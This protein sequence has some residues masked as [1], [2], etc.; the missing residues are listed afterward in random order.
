MGLPKRILAIGA[1][2]DDIEL[3]CAGTLARF[4]GAGSEVQLAVACKGDKGGLAPMGQDLGQLRQLEAREA[5]EI[6]GAP[7]HFLGIPDGAVFDTPQ[8]RMMFLSLLRKTKPDLILTHSPDDYH[9]DHVRVGEIVVKSSWFAASPGHRTEHGPLAA[10]PAVLFVDNRAG[11]RF[12][13]THLVDITETH[14]IKRRMLECHRSQCMGT[15]GPYDSLLE[16]METLSRLRG[17]QCGVRYA[18]GFRVCA[19]F[20]RRR[21]EPLLP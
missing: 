2:P 10:P 15:D 4:L 5:A 16:S 1:H 13:P 20:G 14:D 9:D 18:E 12:E 17:I 8:V 6:L 21:V 19:S 11:I 3:T 7:I